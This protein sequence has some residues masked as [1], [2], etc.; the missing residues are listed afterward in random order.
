MSNYKFYNHYNSMNKDDLIDII[1][2]KNET[3]KK[4]AEMLER[5]RNMIGNK[6]EK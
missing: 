5:Q 2:E 1:Q 4:Q 6:N 3:I